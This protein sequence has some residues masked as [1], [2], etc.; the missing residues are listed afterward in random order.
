MLASREWQRGPVDLPSA[1]IPADHGMASLGLVMQLG[2]H[3][4]GSLTAIAATLV[5]LGAG[6]VK[7]DWLLIALG[8]CILRSVV[9][10]IAG[11]DLCYPR[12]TA[13]RGIADP[14]DAAR[15]YA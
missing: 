9:H 1:G 8:L 10:R 5:L 13:D 14:L 12:T 11:R 4:S 15:V 2:A 6:S 7:R 3:A